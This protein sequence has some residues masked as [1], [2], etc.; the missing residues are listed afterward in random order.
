VL[1]T[2]NP[3]PIDPLAAGDVIAVRDR[4]LLLLQNSG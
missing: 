2:D 3:D 4:S 1:T